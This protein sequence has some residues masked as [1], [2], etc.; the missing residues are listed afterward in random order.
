MGSLF[1]KYRL[2][3][4]CGTVMTLIISIAVIGLTFMI[5]ER[6]SV[7]AGTV[8]QEEQ[9]EPKK[10]VNV[11]V[12][13]DGQTM[14][15]MVA[16]TSIGEV[17]K[18]Y[19]INVGKNDIIS[20]EAEE[21]AGNGMEIRVYRVKY[22]NDIVEE[23]IPYGTQTKGVYTLPHG[24][25]RVAVKGEKGLDKVTYKVMYMD[26]VESS[27]EEIGRETVKAPVT[28]II[29]KS[30]VETIHGREYTKK[31]TVKA[32]SYTGGGRTASGKPAAVGR[33]AVDR[34][35]IPLGTKVYVEGYGFAEAADTGGNI[36]G[37]TIDVYFNSVS[38]CRQWGAKNVTIYILK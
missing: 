16:K 36:K 11:T 10:T 15:L 25:S 12:K 30:I 17:L 33:I 19:N 14:D 24:T 35:V 9:D 4:L 5:A 3:V 8:I 7:Y 18:R 26:G 6:T 2:H 34:N 20:P 37:N 29:E 31:F 28:E 23:E 21:I 13:V 22:K 38:Q 32:Y 1:D 27:R